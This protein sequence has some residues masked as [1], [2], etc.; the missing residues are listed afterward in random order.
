[1]KSSTSEERAVREALRELEP[2]EELVAELRSQ[3]PYHIFR[4][5]LPLSLFYPL[6]SPWKVRSLYCDF[7]LIASALKLHRKTVT[8]LCRK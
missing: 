1:M 5:G 6:D 8:K 2:I 4:S 3:M 7:H